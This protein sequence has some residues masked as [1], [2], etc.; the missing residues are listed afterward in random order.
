MSEPD[1]I[2]RLREH[3]REEA[4]EAERLEALA[5]G[6]DAPPS[7][8]S[9]LERAC[10][11]L[12]DAAVD[13]IVAR[14]SKGAPNAKVVRVAPSRFRRAVLV[15]AG[16]LALAA[17]VALYVTG[18]PTTP[19][20]AELPVYA[21]TAR[22][23]SIERAAVDPASSPRVRVGSGAGRFEVV[24]Q[25]ERA[26]TSPVVAFAFV[27][28]EAGEPEA[29]PF[30]VEVAAGG[31]VRVRGETA[32]LVGFAELRVV[33]GNPEVLSSEG[34]AL[35]RARTPSAPARGSRALSIAIDP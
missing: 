18:G 3:M 20:L 26:V 21:V 23:E 28:R 19:A 14:A 1:L 8:P 30:E 11:P 13:R 35:A 24:L 15:A 31:S 27:V 4:R 25:P 7:S 12:D 32:R 6:D 16:P 17:A 29:A 34:I 5:R 9:E 2:T 33:V 22:G 10:A